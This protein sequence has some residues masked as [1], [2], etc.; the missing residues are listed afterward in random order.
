MFTQENI[1]TK[2]ASLEPSSDAAPFNDRL[3]AS[4]QKKNNSD[5]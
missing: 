4:A 5:E 2:T 1:T 3:F